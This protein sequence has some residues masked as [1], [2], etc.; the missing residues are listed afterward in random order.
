MCDAATVHGT[1]GAPLMRAMEAPIT[2]SWKP[3]TV[4]IIM[5]QTYTSPPLYPAA[6]P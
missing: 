6:V 2:H 1:S 4:H 5:K 3:Y